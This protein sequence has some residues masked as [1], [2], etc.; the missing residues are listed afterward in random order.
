MKCDQGKKILF[1][2]SIYVHFTAFHIPLISL[3]QRH[4]C[5]VHIAAS[6][7]DDGEKEILEDMGVLCR[8]IPF[9]RSPYSL[10]S[11]KA[12]L[13]LKKLLMQERFDLIHVHTPVAAFLGRYAA[14]LTGQGPV[15][16]TAHGFH[17]FK[18]APYQNWLL[19]YP[20]ERVAMAW[21]DGL[22]VLNQE[23][24]GSAVKMGFRQGENLF[25]VPGVGVSPD[26]FYPGGFAEF[27]AAVGLKPVDLAITCVAEFNRNKNHGFLLDVWQEL[28]VSAANVHLLLAGDGPLRKKME[29]KVTAQKIA[30]VHF[31]GY[32]KDIPQILRGSDLFVLVS[33]REGLPRSVM[34]AMATGIP[35]VVSDIRGCRDLV[36]D[37]VSGFLIKPGDSGSLKAA[38]AELIADQRLREEMGAA[39]R[40]KINNFST[41]VV[42]TETGKIYAQMMGMPS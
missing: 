13:Q 19:Y 15:L 26:N 21:T 7:S 27:K 11:I 29:D 28:A 12:F 20:L 24:Y 9:A 10:A 14:R 23:D 3:L 17:F 36:E 4:G 31:L 22:I 16:Y 40:Q 33:L 41:D 5:Q 37:K 30:N 8:D 42:L 1:L 2:A 34:E 38:L 18:G 25:Y 39:A 32:R 35:V 6:P